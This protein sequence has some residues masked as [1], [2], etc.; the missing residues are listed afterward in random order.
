MWPVIL[1]AVRSYAPYLVFP[2]AVVVGTV[3][4]YG[5]YHLSDRDRGRKQEEST[6]EKREE[7][8]MTE[9][10]ETD[11]GKLQGSLPKSILSRNLDNPDQ[12]NR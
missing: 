6:I 3:G 12:Y 7:R 4:Y 8:L 9:S 5:E 2:V 10:A 1:A 11:V